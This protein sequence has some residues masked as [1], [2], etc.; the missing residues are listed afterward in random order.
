LALKSLQ[1]GLSGNDD[2]EEL[3]KRIDNLP[4]ELNDL[5]LSMWDR[6]GADRQMY[7]EKAAFYLNFLIEWMKSTA[8][9]AAPLSYQVALALDS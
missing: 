7:L 8:S 6:L 3:K 9:D 5:Y 1:Q 2:L 4:P